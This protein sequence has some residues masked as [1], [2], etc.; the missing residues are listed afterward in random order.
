MILIP[1]I[2]LKEGRCVR[3]RQGKFDQVTQ[4]DIPP[5]E[6]AA[7]FNQLGAKRLHI[8]DLDGALTGTMQQLPLICSMQ[9]TGITVQAGGGIRSIEQARLCFSA[10]ISNLVI[11]S[12]AIS[13][14]ELTA[15]IVKEIQPQHIILEF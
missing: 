12:I 9:N 13:N 15:Q 3:L 2:D 1:A 11:G 4:F 6:R 10:G 14:P 5:I 8:V 7:Y